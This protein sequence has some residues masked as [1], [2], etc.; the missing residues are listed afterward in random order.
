[1]SLILKST[2]VLLSLIFSLVVVSDISAEFPA[3]S[4]AQIDISQKSF[5]IFWPLV[6]GKTIDQSM[7]YFKNLKEQ[8]RGMLIFGQPQKA[9]YAVLL[10]TKRFLEVVQLTEEGK[11][12]WA[13]KTMIALYARLDEA[14]KALSLAKENK[15]SVG[16][17]GINITNNLNNIEQFTGILIETKGEYKDQLQEVLDKI[18]KLRSLLL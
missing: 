16:E 5:E 2:F 6:A 13:N 1:M 11:T 9:D 7:Y 4:S 12:D 10:S 17:A 8:L 3:S 14:E 15:E 18:Q